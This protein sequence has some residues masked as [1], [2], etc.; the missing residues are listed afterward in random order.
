[1]KRLGFALL[2]CCFASAPAIAC[3]IF[4][5]TDG[6]RALFFN[7]EDWRNPN[8][9][10]WF[11]PTGADYYGSVYVGFDDGRAQGGLNTKG[12]AFDWVAGYVEKWQPAPSMKR[13][14]GNPSERMLESSATVED[15]IAFFQ[16]HREP[17]LSRARILVADRSG[18]SAII[19]VRDGKL[20]I[21][22]AKQS[23]GFGYC[24]PELQKMLAKSLEPT[25]ANGS[26]ILRACLQ[27]GETA[28]KYSNIFDLKSGDIFIFDNPERNDFVKFNL[29]AELAKEGHYYDIPQMRRQLKE[30]PMSLLN[31]MK[32]FFLDEFKPIPDSEPRITERLCAVIRSSMNGTMQSDDFSAE[33]WKEIFPARG[34]MQA[35][36]RKEG[37]L[38]SMTLVAREAEGNMR[39]YRY[40]AEFQNT[41]ALMRFV[42]DEHDKIAQIRS[43]GGEQNAD[44]PD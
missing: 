29:A 14:R 34:E 44:A 41:K 19:G 30:P 11:V 36:L 40:I 24:D 1:M 37:K 2:L 38:I 28:T 16:T 10:I 6:N 22:R 26:G 3:T 21:E 12:L 42:L 13:V 7:N 32:R 5:L 25:L 17:D 27:S 18:A 8:T 43:E 15:A 39:S 33:F 9:R 23:R 20:R 35:E 31:N 4:V